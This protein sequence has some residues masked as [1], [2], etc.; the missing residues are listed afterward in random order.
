M[1]ILS[2]IDQAPAFGGG[3]RPAR[4]SWNSSEECPDC[5][6]V[7]RAGW[8]TGGHGSGD[9]GSD[10]SGGGTGTQ[11][12]PRTETVTKQQTAPPWN[13]LIYNDPV[14]L[15]SYV[16]FVIRRVFGYPKAQAR[17]MMLEVHE[18][19]RSVVWTGERERAEMFVEKLQSHQLLAG[20]ERAG[21]N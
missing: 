12:M 19:G 17:K 18:Q 9:E 8:W 6:R 4:R 21:E 16:T 13:V 15:M 14:N 7:P 20:L 10:D 11:T 1:K 2:V 3:R 5:T